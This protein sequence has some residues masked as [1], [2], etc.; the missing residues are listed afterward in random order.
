MRRRRWAPLL[1]GGVVIAGGFGVALVEVY[2]LPKASIWI[3]VGAAVL[4]VVLI[5]LLGGRKT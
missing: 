3:V 5:R 1:A 2:R 4:L